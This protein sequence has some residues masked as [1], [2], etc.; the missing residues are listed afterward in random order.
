MI[1]DSWPL[2]VEHIREWSDLISLKEVDA[3]GPPAYPSGA[4]ISVRFRCTRC[5]TWLVAFEVKIPSYAD[6]CLVFGD[7]VDVECECGAEYQVE[8]NN[9]S[10]GWDV[11]ID[12]QDSYL[13][14]KKNPDFFQYHLQRDNGYCDEIIPDIEEPKGR[15]SQMDDFLCVAKS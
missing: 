7:T 11:E 4:L 8:A 12:R 2:G 6:G 5:D 1:E 3:I 10:C 15:Q 9:S 13:V 14:K